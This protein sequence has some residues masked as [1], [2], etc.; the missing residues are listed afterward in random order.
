MQRIDLMEQAVMLP[1][2]AVAVLVAVAW[3]LQRF[4]KAPCPNCGHLPHACQ[5]CCREAGR[6]IIAEL[7]AEREAAD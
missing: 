2:L 4:W 3:F 5:A 6:R 7:K 1:L